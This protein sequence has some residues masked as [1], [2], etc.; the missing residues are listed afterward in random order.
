MAFPFL[1]KMVSYSYVRRWYFD[2]KTNRDIYL[3]YESYVTDCTDMEDVLQML[4]GTCSP[5]TAFSIFRNARGNL[6]HPFQN[7]SIMDHDFG[8]FQG[9]GIMEQNLLPH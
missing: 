7:R 2:P 3:E 6:L 9:R 1:E 8:T 5:Y 4:I